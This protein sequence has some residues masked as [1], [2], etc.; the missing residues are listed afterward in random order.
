MGILNSHGDQL[1]QNIK[2]TMKHFC[3]SRFFQ[4]SSKRFKISKFLR[5]RAM[6]HDSIFRLQLPLHG[7]MEVRRNSMSFWN[8][9][10]PIRYKPRQKPVS[11]QIKVS[12]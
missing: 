12:N 4:T 7:N 11:L 6:K 9:F 8:R 5:K 1:K 2:S 3:C 10:M